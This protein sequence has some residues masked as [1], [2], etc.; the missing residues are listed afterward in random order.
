MARSTA[1]STTG[2]KATSK[3][4]TNANAKGSNADIDKATKAGVKKAT[5]VNRVIKYN[6]PADVANPTDRKA[7]RQKV[8]NKL[9]SLEA[10]VAKASSATATKKAK[11]ALAKYQKEVLAS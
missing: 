1:K 2:S 3:A 10:A 5:V 9:K 8:R 11:A 6:Y 7:W 4:K